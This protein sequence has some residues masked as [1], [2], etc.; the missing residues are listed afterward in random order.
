M[1]EKELLNALSEM[2]DTKLAEIRSSMATKEDVAN[3]A[4]K[5]DIVS[6]ATKEDIANMATKED[7]ASMATKED[8]A[9]MATK[10]DLSNLVTKDDLRET[11]NMILSEVDRVQEKSNKHYRAL[12]EEICQLRMEVRSYNIEDLR[13]R[14]RRLESIVL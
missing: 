4:T 6:M 10:D 13:F 1:A 11:E 2:M 5:E 12:K 14:V 7:I 3:M 9:N 8:I